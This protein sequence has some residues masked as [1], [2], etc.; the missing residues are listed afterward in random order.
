MYYSYPGAACIL[1]IEHNRPGLDELRYRVKKNF[2]TN[3]LTLDALD[4][5]TK[6]IRPW[7]LSYV[8]VSVDNLPVEYWLTDSLQSSPICFNLCYIFRRENLEN[9]GTTEINDL[10]SKFKELNAPY[11]RGKM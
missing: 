1:C 2:P 4:L 8:N 11:A 10:E 7:Y 6:E 5:Q 9:E 3:G